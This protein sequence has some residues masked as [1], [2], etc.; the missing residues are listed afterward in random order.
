MG[1][2]QVCTG[3][4]NSLSDNW[5]QL[6]AC[7]WSASCSQESAWWCAC[8]LGCR[9]ALQDKGVSGTYSAVRVLAEKGTSWELVRSCRALKLSLMLRSQPLWSQSASGRRGGG[10]GPSCWMEE[11][12]LW[13]ELTQ[14]LAVKRPGIAGPGMTAYWAL[15]YA[16]DFIVATYMRNCWEHGPC[17]THLEATVTFLMLWYSGSETYQGIGFIWGF[18][19]GPG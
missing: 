16:Q 12:F 19:A 5:I 1:K 15:H 17:L 13:M 4:M 9:D 10:A 7:C 3:V 14:R 18:L 8:F 6:L 2:H 11:L